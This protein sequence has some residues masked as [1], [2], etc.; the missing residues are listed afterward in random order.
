MPEKHNIYAQELG[1][2]LNS[3]DDTEYFKWFLAC[4][5]FGKPVQQGVAKHAFSK[6]MDDGITSPEAIQEAGWDRLVEI[7]DEGHYVR[8]DYSTATRLL[9]MS[10]ALKEN[11]GTFG[12]LL[13]GCATTE[14]VSRRLQQF[15]GVGPKT[16][17]IFLRDMAPVLKKG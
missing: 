3:A 15:K 17:E 14:E 16:A 2:N 4:L 7:L 6:L 12:N 5:L 9:D 11:Y 1:I 8:Y 13:Q 10:A